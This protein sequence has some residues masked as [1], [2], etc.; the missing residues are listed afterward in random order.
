MKINQQTHSTT[1]EEVA[2]VTGDHSERGGRGAY[3]FGV[4]SVFFFAINLFIFNLM[5]SERGGPHKF[6]GTRV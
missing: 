1:I 5:I 6:K 4:S 2:L 3:T